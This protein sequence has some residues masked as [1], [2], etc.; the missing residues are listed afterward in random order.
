MQ[1]ANSKEVRETQA[2]TAVVKPDPRCE[3]RQIVYRVVPGTAARARRLAAIAGACRFVWNELLDQ[4]DQLHVAARMCGGRAP[5]P[6]WFTLGKAFTE[7]RRATPWLQEM[8]FAPV[9]YV[10]KYQAE[11]WKQFF[12]GTAGHPRFKSCGADSVT[13]PDNVRID[14][15]RLWFPKLGWLTLRRRGGNP[16]P[17]GRPVQAVVK[18]VG[19]RWYATVCYE[20]GDVARPDDG[21]VVGVD[22]NAGQV[23]VADGEATRIIRAPE[24]ASLEARRR[25]YQRRM[26]RQHRGSNRRRRTRNR[27]ARTERKLANRRRNWCHHV[28]RD[29][30][31]S[32]VVLENLKTRGMTRSA[33]G[34]VD[35]PGTNVRAKA[36]VNRV[37]LATGWAMLEQMVGYKAPRVVLVAP[38]HTSQTCHGC[39]HVD[40]KSRVSQALFRCTACGHR[41]HADLNAARNIRRRGL[42]QLHGEERFAS[43]RTPATRE[44]D[45]RQA[46]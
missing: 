42:A 13:I 43:G 17:D 35:A 6:T 46:A 28:S 21:R 12:A 11:A 34:T 7:L 32:T 27:L 23:A 44:M 15:G 2:P 41:D 20:V 39:G 1:Q 16:Y 22:R 8:P 24:R 3:Y 25:R 10:L 40:A 18:R 19:R 37:V 5:S 4:Q 33:Q 45:R 31:A 30:A 38:H 36:G 9:R 26:A 29:L 14:N